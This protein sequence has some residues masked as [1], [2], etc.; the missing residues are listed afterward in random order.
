MV[1]EAS[2]FEL[3]KFDCVSEAHNHEAQATRTTQRRRD[4]EQTMRDI[5]QS[6]HNRYTCM[7][8]AYIQK[9]NHLGKTTGG[10]H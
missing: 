6:W 9:K 3:L 5:T 10:L 8:K 7:N 2:R 1:N 4:E